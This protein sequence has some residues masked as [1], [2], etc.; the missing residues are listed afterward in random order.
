MVEFDHHVLPFDQGE[1]GLAAVIKTLFAARITH[2]YRQFMAAGGQLHAVIDCG[3]PV[4]PETTGSVALLI[5]D[6]IVGTERDVDGVSTAR[7]V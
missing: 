6:L 7:A 1:F 3:N 2:A 5:Q 4:I